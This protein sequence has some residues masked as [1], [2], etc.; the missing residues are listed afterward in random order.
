MKAIEAFLKKYDH[1]PH[2]EKCMALFLAEERILKIKQVM[3]EERNQSE[4]MQE[5]LLKLMNDLQVLKGIQQEKK[6]PAA[7]SFTSYGNFS[8]IDDV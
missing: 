4:V 5:L 3:E 6:K 8:M 2:E 1:I 7:Q